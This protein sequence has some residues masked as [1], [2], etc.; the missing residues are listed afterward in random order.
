MGLIKSITIFLLGIVVGQE[1][2]VPRMKPI[3]SQVLSELV[4]SIITPF[5]DSII[6]RRNDDEPP[7]DAQRKTY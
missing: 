4:S 5:S 6:A 3:L 7:R 1:Y 2:H